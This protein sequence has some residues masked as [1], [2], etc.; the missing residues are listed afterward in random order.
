MAFFRS[1]LH[2]RP[3]FGDAGDDAS[4]LIG[5]AATSFGAGVAQQTQASIDLQ[6]ALLAQQGQIDPTT[7]I[8]LAG[9][10]LLI[11]MVMSKKKK[12]A[13]ATS[14]TTP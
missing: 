9:G 6:K 11:L 10:A 13:A 5:G 12:S 2:A 4:A 3:G 7:L 14:P 1:N 8:V